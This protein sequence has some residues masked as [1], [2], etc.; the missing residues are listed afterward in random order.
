MRCDRMTTTFR[1]NAA[2]SCPYTVVSLMPKAFFRNGRIVP[3]F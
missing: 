3:D 2:G 1:A